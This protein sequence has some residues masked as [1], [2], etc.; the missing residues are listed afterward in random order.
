MKFKFAIIGITV[1][2]ILLFVKSTIDTG[3]FDIVKLIGIVA[4][5]LLLFWADRKLERPVNKA[6]LKRDIKKEIQ[7]KE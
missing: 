1:L 5:A 6:S 3:S 2:M 4:I 7:H